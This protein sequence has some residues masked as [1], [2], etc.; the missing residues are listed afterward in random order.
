M[1][2][3]NNDRKQYNLVYWC[4]LGENPILYFYLLDN[5]IKHLQRQIN[6]NSEKKTGLLKYINKK[7]C[8]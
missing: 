8:L 4:T 6:W 7:C 3:W 5:Y 2:F 1:T